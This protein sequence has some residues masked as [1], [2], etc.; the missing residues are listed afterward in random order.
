MGV[1]EQQDQGPP[2]VEIPSEGETGFIPI[3][4]GDRELGEI[5]QVTKCN[6]SHSQMHEMGN[7]LCRQVKIEQQ[8]AMPQAATSA[9]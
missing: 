4:N 5:E 2:R 3:P 9:R 1:R 8:R 6:I 7:L